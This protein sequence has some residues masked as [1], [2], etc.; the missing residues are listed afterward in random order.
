MATTLRE[1]YRCDI[2]IAAVGS[3]ENGFPIGCVHLVKPH[4]NVW[5]S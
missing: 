2:M 5:R 3:E 4:F 1:M